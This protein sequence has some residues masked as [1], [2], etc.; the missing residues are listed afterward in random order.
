[1]DL[2]ECHDP[3]ATPRWVAFAL[4]AAGP[5]SLPTLRSVIA[6][7]LSSR[8]RHKDAAIIMV[9]HAATPARKPRVRLPAE[10]RIGQILDAALAEFA[11]H[12]FAAT[13]M[14]DIAA[15]AG[16]SKGGLYAHFAS[17]EEVFEA[18]LTHRLSPTPADTPF[19]D[20]TPITVDSVIDSI[21]GD[22]YEQFLLD[23]DVEL[24]VRL[25]VAEGA[26]VTQLVVLWQNAFVEPHLARIGALIAR[27]VAQGRLKAGIAADESWLLIAPVVQVL[28][29]RIV[30]GDAYP[31]ALAHCKHAHTRLLRELLTP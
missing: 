13:R 5:P 9:A 3:D 23:P 15:R 1:M 6:I 14:D 11:T 8:R 18:L 25:L 22:I 21:I 16:L 29:G 12:G 10:V 4:A 30:A 24:M 26:R 31:R 27:G 20:T 2:L 28:I 17:K 7:M 19:D